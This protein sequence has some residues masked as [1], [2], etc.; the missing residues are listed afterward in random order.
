M[1]PNVALEPSA[2]LVPEEPAVPL[3]PLV[4]ES[5]LSPVRAKVN[6]QSSPLE[7][8]LAEDSE[9][10]STSTLIYPLGSEFELLI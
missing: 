1:P 10:E 9:I 4:P 5:P 3:V 2:P 8:G 7:K 6:I